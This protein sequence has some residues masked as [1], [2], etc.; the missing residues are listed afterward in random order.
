MTNDQIEHYK[1]QGFTVDDDAK[2]E[3]SL[4]MVTHYDAQAEMIAWRGELARLRKVEEVAREL[5]GRVE[6]N[7][8]C[9]VPKTDNPFCVIC[10]E[11]WEFHDANC[12]I[13]RARALG[14]LE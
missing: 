6:M 5:A 8:L 1:E 3:D 10:L 12:L 9:R 2:D 14:L 11:D 13:T 4:R 7:S